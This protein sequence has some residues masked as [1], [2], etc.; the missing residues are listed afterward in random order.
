LAPEAAPARAEQPPERDN[1]A[2]VM[3][4][5]TGSLNLPAG[6][7]ESDDRPL[8]SPPGRVMMIITVLALIYIAIMTWFIAHMPEE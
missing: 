7:I 6:L 5:E 1:G 2:G 8:F 4:P 3:R